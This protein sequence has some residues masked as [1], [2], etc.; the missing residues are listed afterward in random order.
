MDYPTSKLDKALVNRG[1][2]TTARTTWQEWMSR[3]DS[4][5]SSALLAPQVIQG[6]Q[7][8]WAAQYGLAPSQRTGY[9]PETP[10]PLQRQVSHLGQPG[11]AEI[12][13]RPYDFATTRHGK[14]GPS[15]LGHPVSFEIV[16]PTLKSRDLVHQ[17]VL[18]TTGTNDVLTLD[19]CTV[20]STLAVPEALPVTLDSIE[21]IY[22]ITTVPEEG[23]YLVVSLTGAPGYLSDATGVGVP[24]Q[25]GL[26][27]GLIGDG[28]ALA[29]VRAPITTPANGVEQRA[30]YEI[31]RV[32][33]LRAG[34]LELDSSKRISDFFTVPGGRTPIIRAVT[35]FKPAAARVV[36]VPGSGSTGQE[37]VF[38]LVPPEKS[39]NADLMPPAT[40]WTTALTFDPWLGFN[41]TATAGTLPGYLQANALPIPRAIRQGRGHVQGING[42][43][44]VLLAPGLLKVMVDADTTIEAADLGR[45][46]HITG[47][48][49]TRDAELSGVADGGDRIGDPDL[50]RLLGW[51]E[52]VRSDVGGSFYYLRMITQVDPLTGVPFYGSTEYLHQ[53]QTPLPAV[54]QEI[55]LQWMVHEPISALWTSTYLSPDKLESARLTHIIDPEWV[56]PTAKNIDLSD[57]EG[58]PARPDKAIFGTEGTGGFGEN[59]NPGSLMDLGFRMVLFPAKVSSVDPAKLVPDFDQPINS[60]E[61]VLDPT[62]AS[63]E[64][65][66]LEVDY[67]GGLVTLSHPP[68]AGAGCQLA[69]DAT[70]LT[71]AANPRGEMVFFAS[72]VP[73]S[74]EP[75]QR[76]PATRVTGGQSISAVGSSCNWETPEAADLYGSRL[77]WPLAVGQTITSGQDTDIKLNVALTALDLPPVG[78]VELQ[79]GHDDPLTLYTFVD[80]KSR[81]V[82]TFGY[83]WVYYADPG[84]GGNTTLKKCFGGGRNTATKTVSALGPASVVLRRDLVLPNRADGSIGTD[85]T[86]DTT[87]GSNKRASAL[88]FKYATMTAEPDGSVTVDPTDPRVAKHEQLFEELFSSWVLSGGEMLTA[89]PT[90]ASDVLAFSELTVLISGIRS[91]LPAQSVFMSAP[92]IYVYI[93]STTPACPVYATT[94][95]LPLPLPND[96]L[97]GWYRYIGGPSIIDY[98]DL[99]Q[100]MVNIDKRLDITVGAPSGF[101]QPADAHFATL[102][103]AVMYAAA[104]MDPQVGSYGRYR[105]IVVIGP[106]VE[107]LT[108][109]PIRPRCEGLVIEGAA[110]RQ[111]GGLATSQEVVWGGD[112]APAL[113]DLTGCSGIVMRN[114]V[115]RYTYDAAP[116]AT[117]RDRCLFTL[118]AQQGGKE[119]QDA[120]FENI[121]LLGPAHGFF[122]CNDDLAPNL[123]GFNK[124]TF[125]NC[126]APEMTDFGVHVGPTVTP[127]GALILDGCWFVVAKLGAP[128]PPEL[129]GVLDPERAIVYGKVSAAS[130]WVIQDCFFAG[131]YIGIYL[132]GRLHTVTR[133]LLVGTDK[134]AVRMMENACRLHDVGV[135]ACYTV[136]GVLFGLPGKVLIQGAGTDL[137]MTGCLITT[138]IAPVVADDYAVYAQ[139]CA[140]AMTDCNLAQ[141][142]LVGPYSIVK[143]C[144]VTDVLDLATN[145]K[146]IYNQV[147]AGAFGEGNIQAKAYCIVE[148]N[149]CEGVF[150][151]T[152]DPTATNIRSS[153]NLFYGTAADNIVYDYCNHT[154]D[155]FAGVVWVKGSE[156]TFTGI[157]VTQGL[158]ALAAAGRPVGNAFQGC[159]IAF[160]ADTT[161]HFG[162]SRFIGND[163]SSTGGP[164][165]ITVDGSQNIFE[166]NRLDLTLVIV[167]TDAPITHRTKVHGNY[168]TGTFGGLHTTGDY[169]SIV[170]NFFEGTEQAS[171]SGNVAINATGDHLVIGNNISV[172]TGLKV[173][174][175]VDGDSLVQGNQIA[176]VGTWNSKDTTY[177]GNWVGG[178][179]VQ[180][181]GAT[182]SVVSGNSFDAA[183][184]FNPT[185]LLVDGNRFNNV[186]VTITAAATSQRYVNN[187]VLGSMVVA[188]VG[189]YSQAFL[190][191][192]FSG[193][194]SASGATAFLTGSTLD[195]NTFLGAVDLHIG[196]TVSL[197]LCTVQGNQFL[198]TVDFGYASYTTVNGN[199][200]AGSVDFT[201]GENL[202]VQGNKVAAN[203]TMA[204]CATSDC[205]GNWVGGDLTITSAPESVIGDNKVSGALVATS[206]TSATIQGNRVT[207]NLTVSSCAD[208]T[209][210]GNRVG[211]NLGGNA[212]TG[213]VIQGNYVTGTFTALTALQ[214]V[215]SGNHVT[216]AVDVAGSTDVVLTGNYFGSTLNVLS[217]DEYVLTGNRVVGAVT[218]DSGGGAANS[219]VI[220]G[221]RAASINDTNVR[222]ANNLVAVGNKVGNGTQLFD[223]ALGTASS[224]SGVLNITD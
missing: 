72:F 164:W 136:A 76:S 141:R 71:H 11:M 138:T 2:S 189:G 91:V 163:L 103:E 49:T 97:I 79:N 98:Q 156:N 45:V 41:A 81:R 43:V 52:I 54:G 180:A 165:T 194:F 68:K 27:D 80:A 51:W 42:E 32:I 151:P 201:S 169:L 63:T 208:S 154:D 57:T 198:S 217:T 181:A 4:V 152:D 5:P 124:I 120:L 19:A 48:D 167:A 204:F 132:E 29:P 25:G 99:R 30:K 89:L 148:G 9:L 78:F 21:D 106:T 64:K 88:R 188:G 20:N 119:L 121:K 86:F 128:Q 155:T 210:C 26:G 221:N 83:T 40:V 93:D 216:G 70:I 184:T 133:T 6:F 10:A 142:A 182:G 69:P 135:T 175:S 75:G 1:A 207:G 36:A 50:D 214:M 140:V 31:F 153:K 111:D 8:S 85:F 223:V 192:Q 92:D 94:A 56:Q 13:F 212:A 178:A 101:D 104:T 202:V 3:H 62:L 60:N 109:L 196:G 161:L 160:L 55:R 37:Q 224:V 179:V 195:G 118:D 143:G 66:F 77:H 116:S 113:F 67:A 59:E 205:S 137:I 87:Y 168:F 110:R 82:S 219:G 61:L 123:T 186:G 15:L 24:G 134:L 46:I 193:T 126:Y 84:N 146:A 199:V 17:W 115:F 35:L 125:R 158:K 112:T 23:L 197:T 145:A 33:E 209:V 44:P 215:V 12:N 102:A 162:A 16:G 39:L 176:G 190:G 185:F 213:I 129:S 159:W 34:I 58:S 95:S 127:A 105:R 177:S 28:P 38:A 53:L 131:G 139:G 173:A 74:Q 117:P 65:Q 22:G 149:D 183:V 122:Y 150:N 187:V 100:P 90:V 191:N 144:L 47:I 203:L 222:P 200:F 73:F 18:D 218:F 206:S 220:V 157:R 211:G 114:L 170:D 7:G 174:H 130:S 172:L 96:V 147:V 14:Y 171:G 107:D 108:L 166:G